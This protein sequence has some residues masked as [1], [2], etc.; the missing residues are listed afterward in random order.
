MKVIILS[1]VL[2]LSA[3]STTVPVKQK[4]PVAPKELL[5]KCPQ[6]NTVE[7]GKTA[8]TDLVK[9]VVENYKL[10]YQCSLKQE[11]WSDWYTEQ[12]E[13]FDQVNK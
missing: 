13:V 7:Q 8:I 10:Y 11:G 5:E 3:C 6:L 12:K 2:F 1:L 9:T 4:F